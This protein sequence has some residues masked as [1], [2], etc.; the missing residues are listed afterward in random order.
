[1]GKKRLYKS[2]NS[3]LCGVCGGIAEYLNIDPAIV[4]LV[5]ALLV[6]FTGF[7]IPIYIILALVLEDNPNEM[8]DG[9]M[10]QE[11]ISENPDPTFFR[12][13]FKGNK[14][15]PKEE[16]PIDV[17]YRETTVDDYNQAEYESDEPIGFNV[18][19]A[20]KNK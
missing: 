15:Q 13:L 11:Y 12:D 8:G 18:E 2:R 9:R 1:M 19:D 4:R 20:F 3:K 6:F 5:W 16:E 10:N 17:S 7:G 14:S